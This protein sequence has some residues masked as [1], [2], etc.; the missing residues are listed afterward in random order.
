[1]P[2]Q[3]PSVGTVPLYVGDDEVLTFKQWCR[4][5]HFSDRTGRRILHGPKDKRPIITQ[6]SDKRIGITRAN[7]RR[8]QEA[9]GR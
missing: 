2:K 4:L 6:L 9:R 7:N 3:I 1:M 5:N 8:W